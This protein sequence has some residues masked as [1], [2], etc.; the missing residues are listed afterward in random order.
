MGVCDICNT[1]G[2]GELVSSEDMRKAVFKN[3]FDPFTK[4]LVPGTAM[5]AALGMD[6]RQAYE[7]WKGGIVA[8]DTSDWNICASCMAALKPYLEG[9][10]RPTG[11][12]SSQASL[13]PVVAGMAK[14]EAERR[15]GGGG[16]APQP[17]QQP[18]TKSKC[19]I[20]TA[21]CETPNAPEVILLRQFRD[22][23][24]RPAPLGRVCVRLYEIVS[25]PI[26]GII[27]RNSFLRRVVRAVLI[28]PLAAIAESHLS[29]KS[30]EK[31]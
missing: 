21:A 7:D 2:M 10:P 20:A 31:S 8:Q 3:G 4:G 25:P 13:N 30:K 26:A 1:P 28:R 24:L 29:F 5:F 11:V 27:S 14:A 19:F 22:L 17:D 18:E 23:V 15:Y 12:K 16:Q 6:S 9:A